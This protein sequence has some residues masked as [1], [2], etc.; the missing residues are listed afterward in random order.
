MGAL[1]EPLAVAVYSVQRAEIRMGDAVLV[2]GAGPIGLM[3]LL[4]AK[5]AGASQVAITGN[6]NTD[7]RKRKKLERFQEETERACSV[8]SI[9]SSLSIKFSTRV[10]NPAWCC[11][12]TSCLCSCSMFLHG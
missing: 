3:C 9:I 7:E 4:A 8:D 12:K 10:L 1:L 5:A 6:Q 11:L 2:L